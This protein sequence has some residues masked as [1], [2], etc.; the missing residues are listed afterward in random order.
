[1]KKS[2]LLHQDSLSVIDKM[3][4]EQVGKLLRLMKSY[5]NWNDYICDDFSVELVFEQFKNQFDRDLEKYQNVCERNAKN[6]KHGGRPKLDTDIKPKKPSGIITN[7]KKPRK[8]DND[9]DNDNDSDK[10]N[11]NILPIGNTT[12]VDQEKKE[13]ISTPQTQEIN[14]MIDLVKNACKD[15]GVVYAPDPKERQ[16]AKHMLGKKFHAEA[17]TPLNT[18][19]EY[20]VT[21]VIAASAKR[22]FMKQI[23]N[24]TTL[25]YNRG[26]V[27]NRIM[28]EKKEQQAKPSTSF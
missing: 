27:I 12:I 9:N 19:I 24:C 26:S 16:Y 3:S 25:Y 20:F 1:M 11:N 4:D 17:I 18:T 14:N 21:N 8:A 7:P 22:K 2:F 10:E 28:L 15:A 13:Y 6:W 23:Y 5:H